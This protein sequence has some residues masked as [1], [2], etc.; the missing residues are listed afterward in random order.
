[1][2]SASGCGAA[3]SSSPRSTGGMTEP[4]A[5]VEHTPARS[6]SP[7]AAR[8]AWITADRIVRTRSMPPTI[9][10]KV[11]SSG[12]ERSGGLAADFIQAPRAN[13]SAA[14]LTAASSMAALA[15]ATSGTTSTTMLA[16]A[17]SFSL[18]PRPERTASNP[19]SRISSPAPPRMLSRSL[20]PPQ[21]HQYQHYDGVDMFVKLGEHHYWDPDRNEDGCLVRRQHW[22]LVR[23]S[24]R[25]TPRMP[26]T[27]LSSPRML[28]GAPLARQLP[29]P[30]VEVAQTPPPC[31][32]PRR[33]VTEPLA[34]RPAAEVVARSMTPPTTT[35]S[36]PSMEHMKYE[37]IMPLQPLINNE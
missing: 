6:A 1:V 19:G 34:E 37:R 28:L 29:P 2:R 20:S 25:A 11:I 16:P 9:L 7:P 14:V 33:L 12:V 36:K 22:R 35:G 4:I 18:L 21:Q 3:T 8:R 26:V 27:A 17:A 15:T 31:P 24:P 13:S 10:R 5:R 30:R 23:A 32:N